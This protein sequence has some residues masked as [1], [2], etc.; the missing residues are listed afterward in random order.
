MARTVLE[1]QQQLRQRRA[2]KT[3]L[4]ATMQGVIVVGFLG[5][6]WLCTTLYLFASAKYS[7]NNSFME[8]HLDRRKDQDVPVGDGRKTK[9]IGN[10][11]NI[12]SD[13]R[14]LTKIHNDSNVGIDK[15][16]DKKTEIDVNNPV[17]LT[18]I[19]FPALDENGNPG[20][21]HNATR[22]HNNPPNFDKRGIPCVP[23]DAVM[24]LFTQRVYVDLAAHERADKLVLDRAND[25]TKPRAKIFCLIYTV[26]KN[27]NFVQ[28]IRETWGHRCD[29]FLAASNVTDKTIDAVNIPH[30]GKETYENMWQKVRAMWTYVYV[31]YFDDYDWF[32]IGGDDMYVVSHSLNCSYLV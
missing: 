27:R 1:P 29:G 22:L 11:D 12:T 28:S 13:A 6:A 16:K 31:N 25:Y 3:P 4:L 18:G 32:H 26:D 17:N 14:M 7:A 23:N 20:Y 2:N 9:K 15:S 8:I 24:Q 21:V 5:L 10:I 19:Y 30:E